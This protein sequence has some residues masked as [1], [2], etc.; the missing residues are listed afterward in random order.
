MFFTAMQESRSQAATSDS[1][2]E[3]HT[4]TDAP[5][6]VAD[7]LNELLDVPL[8]SVNKWAGKAKLLAAEEIV[9]DH[10]RPEIVAQGS[11]LVVRFS[12]DLP[13]VRYLCGQGLDGMVS[14]ATAAKRKSLH[15]A[16]FVRRDHVVRLQLSPGLLA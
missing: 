11:A 13:E 12:D 8:S 14:K 7:S 3:S 10:P 5:S 16:R 4:R 9:N 1:V 6:S 15:A 2:S